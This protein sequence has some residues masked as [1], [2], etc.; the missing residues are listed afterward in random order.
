MLHLIDFGV[1]EYFVGR[2]GRHL[3]QVDTGVITG[4]LRY[5]S[6]N[7]HKGLS[8]SRRDD[9]ESMLYMLLQVSLDKGT[10]WDPSTQSDKEVKSLKQDLNRLT[11]LGDIPSEVFSLL[12][13]TR[14]LKFEEVPNYQKYVRRF[15]RAASKLGININDNVFDWAL[16]ATLI[17]KYP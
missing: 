16:L 4:T 7:S 11:R 6:L 14:R 17:D 15:D 13:Y 3:P 8:L 2:R 10:P 12:D 9:M 1:S 5:C